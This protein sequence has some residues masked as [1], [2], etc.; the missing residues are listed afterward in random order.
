MNYEQ[1]SGDNRDHPPPSQ[2][3]CHQKNASGNCARPH[4]TGQM[5]GKWIETRDGVVQQVRE[6][7]DR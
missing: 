5:I 2:R 4:V 1:R 7:M 6:E 3:Q